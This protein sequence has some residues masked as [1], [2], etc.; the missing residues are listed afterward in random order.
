MDSKSMNRD[1]IKARERSSCIQ[2]LQELRVTGVPAQTHMTCGLDYTGHQESQVHGHRTGPLAGKT[3]T[4]P[5]F[6]C[7]RWWEYHYLKSR[8]RNKA[9]V[10]MGK[11]VGPHAPWMEAPRGLCAA[12]NIHPAAP[13]SHTGPICHHTA[14]EERNVS[15]ITAATEPSPTPSICSS[16]GSGAG[17]FT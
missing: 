4:F 11:A 7:S 9:K 16:V 2:C 10:G 17:S 14:E 8:N 5:E 15:S 1:A 13:L 12:W 6:F 3:S